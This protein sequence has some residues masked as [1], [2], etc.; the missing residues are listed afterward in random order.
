MLGGLLRVIMM[1]NMAWLLS[2]AASGM[3]T[4]LRAQHRHRQRHNELL[5]G[6]MQ[7]CH[8]GWTCW[9]E[10]C[11]QVYVDSHAVGTMHGMV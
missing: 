9:A 6:L 10:C 1:R 8:S 11:G 2:V 4:K 7:V 5:Q 3:D